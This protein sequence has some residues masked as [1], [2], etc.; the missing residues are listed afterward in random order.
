[1]EKMPFWL[2]LFVY[3]YDNSSNNN[4]KSNEFCAVRK[5]AQT[6]A[7]KHTHTH[8]VNTSFCEYKGKRL[9]NFVDSFSLVIVKC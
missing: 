8:I 2:R 5:Y 6:H 9:R 3:S 1:M 4:N 7:P